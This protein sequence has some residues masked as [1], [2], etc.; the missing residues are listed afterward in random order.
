MA[1]GGITTDNSLI[2]PIEHVEH[3]SQLSQS[4]ILEIDN[5]KK[6]L[7]KKLENKDNTLLFIE[8]NI[9]S[10]KV[11]MHAHIQVISIPNKYITN[12][13]EIIESDSSKCSLFF[14]EVPIDVPL[15]KI[16][17]DRPYFFIEY[18]DVRLYGKIA[19][20]QKFNMQLGR[21]IVSKILKLPENND[22]RTSV[23][24]KDEETANAERYKSLIE[25]Q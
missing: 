16:I 7:R 11:S 17:S 8:R 6:L 5:Y 9:P 22:W 25:S 18:G 19:N 12:A 21:Q 3:L 15:Y 14:D 23:M 20:T 10:T 2:I 24:S 4:A 1:K 13:R